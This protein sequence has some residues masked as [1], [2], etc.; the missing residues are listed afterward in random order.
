MPIVAVAA[1]VQPRQ[2]NAV[3]EGSITQQRQIEAVAA[4]GHQDRTRA[5][6]IDRQAFDEAD[7]QFRLRLLADRAAADLGHRPGTAAIIPLGIEGGDGDDPIDRRLEEGRRRVL[8]IARITFPQH[9]PDLGVRRVIRP[10]EEA[11][12]HLEVGN[13][14]NIEDDERGHGS[15]R[16]E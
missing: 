10:S 7:Q 3:G 13:G 8:A 1:G 4:E 16:C 6:A 12:R 15:I 14:L 2:W 5:A 9:P 11:A